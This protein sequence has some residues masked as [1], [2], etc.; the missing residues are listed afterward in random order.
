MKYLIPDAIS[1][2]VRARTHY[3]A[4][5]LSVWLRLI[6]KLHAAGSSNIFPQVETICLLEIIAIDRSYVYLKCPTMVNLLISQQSFL[7]CAA[8]QIFR[9][10]GSFLSLQRDRSPWGLCPR[11]PGH[12]QE[13]DS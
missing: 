7:Q 11:I 5:Q 9:A 4:H 1:S 6:P 8:Q 12:K 10:R 3:R 13:H 2:E